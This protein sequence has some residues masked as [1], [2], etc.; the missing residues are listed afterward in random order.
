MACIFFVVMYSQ[1]SIIRETFTGTQLRS[2]VH[3]LYRQQ[4]FLDKVGA[5]THII[6][7]QGYYNVN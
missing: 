6:K 7:L 2:T 1:K 4:S 5:Q 3:R